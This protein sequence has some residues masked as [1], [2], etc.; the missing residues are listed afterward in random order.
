MTAPIVDVP[1]VVPPPETYSRA[2]LLALI[3]LDA[4]TQL[5]N[6]ADKTEQEDMALA[7]RLLS[8]QQA[9][10]TIV[11]N[12]ALLNGPPKIAARTS[13]ML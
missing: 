7:S 6:D 2:R 8:M 13:T 12:D 10:Q 5:R 9:I 3:I 1:A 4:T 11:K